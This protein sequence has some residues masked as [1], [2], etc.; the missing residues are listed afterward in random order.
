MDTSYYIGCIT[1]KKIGF[2]E[3]IHSVSPLY[4]ILGKPD[5]NVEEINRDKYLIFGSTDKSK[6]VLTKYTE[7]CDKIKYLIK[8]TING[9]TAGEYGKDFMKLRFKSD[10]NLPLNKI[11]RLHMLSV[12]VT[13]S[14]EEKGKYYPETF[15]DECLYE[16]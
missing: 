8:A 3:N 5:G 9:G 12:I 10:D 4:L 14:F 16:L 1:I 7:F 6:E 13:S 2:Y 11:L 15:L